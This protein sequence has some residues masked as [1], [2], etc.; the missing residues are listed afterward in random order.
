MSALDRIFRWTLAL[1]L[2]AFA[3]LLATL[4]GEAPALTMTL[5]PDAL[6]VIHTRDRRPPT[7][8]TAGRINLYPIPNPSGKPKAGSRDQLR[9]P[10]ARGPR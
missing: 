1:V 5:H 3:I 4:V 2:V 8:R 7:V 10:L 9:Q 6:P